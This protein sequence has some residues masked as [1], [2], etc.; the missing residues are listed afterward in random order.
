MD[1][2]FLITYKVLLI[3]QSAY[4]HDLT[5]TLRKSSRHPNTFNTFF[6]RP[7]HFKNSFFLGVN[8]DWNKVDLD[9]CDINN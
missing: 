9:V 3:K 1:E 8:N 6:Y 4:I 5:S 2:T 7:K